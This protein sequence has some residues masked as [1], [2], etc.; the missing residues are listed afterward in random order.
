[1]RRHNKAPDHDG[2]LTEMLVAPGEYGVEERTRFRNMV[3][4]HGYIPEELNKSIFITLPKI[5]ETP[6]FEKHCTISLLVSTHSHD[7]C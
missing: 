2:D 7:P 5:S 6:K 3:Y 4:N 1:M